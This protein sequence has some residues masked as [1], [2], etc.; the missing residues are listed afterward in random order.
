MACARLAALR[1]VLLRSIGAS[2]RKIIWPATSRPHPALGFSSA[3]RLVESSSSMAA[4][5][6]EVSCGLLAGRHDAYD[7]IILDPESIPQSPATFTE[8]LQVSMAAWRGAGVKGVWMRLPPTHAHCIGH[9]VDAGFE[10]HHAEKEYVMLTC[11]LPRDVP[12]PLLPNAS[13]QVG[14]GAFVVNEK[15]EV[16]V[17]Q[18]RLGPLRGKGVWKLPTGLVIAGEDITEAAEREVGEETGIKAKFDAVL[19]MRQAHGVAFGKSDMFFLMA[20]K[21]EPGQEKV[22]F[23]AAEL[24]CAAWMPLDDYVALPTHTPLNLR[25]MNSCLAYLDGSYRGLWARRVQ[26]GF[27][28][29]QDLLMFGEQS[30]SGG[31]DEDAWLGLVK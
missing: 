28:A 13:H 8:A 9:A 6:T 23:Q 25:L 18:E 3:P 7:G 29:T 14:V 20:L 5:G 26:S 12:S 15:R 10:F 22:S 4:A 21:P 16:L 19:A 31:R 27:K 1:S 11:W 24:E 30:L 17:V 2:P